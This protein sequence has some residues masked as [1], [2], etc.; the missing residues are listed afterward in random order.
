[1]S[2]HIINDNLLD[3]QADIIIHGVNSLGVM[4]AG[5]AKQIRRKWTIVYEEYLRK[6]K[7]EGWKLGDIQLVWVGENPRFV[8]NCCTQKDFGRENRLYADYDAIQK[9]ITDVVK[10]AGE[11]NYSVATPLIGTGLANGNRH[12]VMRIIENI[13]LKYPDVSITIYEL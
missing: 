2:I 11:N 3:S 8:A 10:F 13:S 12:T 7:Q 9:C 4:G 5:L 6:Y 1:M